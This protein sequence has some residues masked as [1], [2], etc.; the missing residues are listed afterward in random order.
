MIS[1]LSLYRHHTLAERALDYAS[2]Y[3]QDGTIAW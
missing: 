3:I 2:L 1:L